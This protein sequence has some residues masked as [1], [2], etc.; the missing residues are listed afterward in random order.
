MA[1]IEGV[2]RA[3]L[4][5]FN[6]RISEVTNLLT[7]RDRWAEEPLDC[8]FC[9]DKEADSREGLKT[10]TFSCV[11][12]CGNH[13]IES[14]DEFE[15]EELR[16]LLGGEDPIQPTTISNILN[17]VAA[18]RIEIGIFDVGKEATLFEEHLHCDYRQAT[19]KS[20]R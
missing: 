9:V 4:V 14:L 6:Q 17:T 2:R 8:V 1:G 20:S 19:N 3:D 18:Q 7:D 12:A 10:I 13:L 5:K 11:N 15:Y 16:E